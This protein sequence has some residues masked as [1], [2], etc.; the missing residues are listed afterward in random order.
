[1]PDSLH[2]K[3]VFQV[4]SALKNLV[5]KGLLDKQDKVVIK[6]LLINEEEKEV[7]SFINEKYLSL[8]DLQ[9]QELLLLEYYMEHKQEF[10]RKSLTFNEN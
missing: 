4:Q 8:E 9:Q 6:G 7:R 10:Q 1:M 5:K 2:F 3:Q